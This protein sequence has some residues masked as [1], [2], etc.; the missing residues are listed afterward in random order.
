MASRIILTS[1]WILL[2]LK[3]LGS[4]YEDWSIVSDETTSLNI[5]GPTERLDLT[6]HVL[7]HMTAIK[8]LSEKNTSDER[9]KRRDEYLASMSLW[10]PWT[11]ISAASDK[12]QFLATQIV[13]G[14]KDFLEAESTT[15]YGSSSSSSSCFLNHITMTN[16][17]QLFMPQMS[18]FVA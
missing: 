5:V 16:S 4:E 1:K 3:A 2:S 11:Q 7:F 12:R 15:C 13:V 6:D 9:L 17:C 14:E 8:S 18:T 10:V